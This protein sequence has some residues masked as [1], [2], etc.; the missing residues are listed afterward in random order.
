M[1]KII[2]VIAAAALLFSLGGCS[3]K[4]KP[5]QTSAT[6][7][8]SSATT[9]SS[10][11][12][13]LNTVSDTYGVKFGV[14]SDVHQVD[15]DTSQNMEKLRKALAYYKSSGIK[16]LIVDGDISD[17]ATVGGYQNFNKA[18]NEAFPDASTAPKKLLVMGNH[19]YNLGKKDIDLSRSDFMRE[20]NLGS[21]N[22]SIVVDGYHF[23]G[24]STESGALG[25][26]FTDISKN[27]LRQELAKAAA[28]DPKKPIF[29]AFHQPI[30]GTLWGSEDCSDALDSVLKDYPQVIEFSGHTHR[31]LADERSIYQK[32]YTCVG[33]G[34][35]HYVAL[36]N[37]EPYNG[38]LMSQGLL[39]GIG[40]NSVDIERYDFMNNQKVKNDWIMKLPLSKQTF[41]YTD[42][43]LTNRSTPYFDKGASIQFSSIKR[44]DFTMNYPSAK[45]DDFVYEYKIVIQDASTNKTV[46]TTLVPT[47]FY[48]GLSKMAKK[49]AIVTSTIYNDSNTYI[50]ALSANKKY[51]IRITALD[52]F[53]KESKP[54][55]GT[56]TTKK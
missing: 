2:S 25:G 5:L 17:A 6:E 36:D 7:A 24:L 54:I 18:F 22:N 27:W 11:S 56:V 20:L 33:T 48:M 30:K 15:S 31:P 13:T 19:D 42:A 38:Y 16:L 49:Q 47:D 29:V 35:L 3:G 52:S 28:D 45:D 37:W 44:R 46:R 40:S 41:T 10:T 4:S 9:S 8:T 1:K 26:E 32:D 50:P 53:G 51:N 43:R 34:E 12:S 14:L 55:T 21:I 39:V 23:I